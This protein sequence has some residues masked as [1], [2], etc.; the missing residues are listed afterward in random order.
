MT[1]WSGWSLIKAQKNGC[2]SRTIAPKQAVAIARPEMDIVIGIKQFAHDQIVRH[3]EER[4]SS[5]S[6]SPRSRH[7]ESG[8]FSDKDCK[9]RA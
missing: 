2:L 5:C 7:L 1:L 3:I 6:C 9:T 8:R 4:L